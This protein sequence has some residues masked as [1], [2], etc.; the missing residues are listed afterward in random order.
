[1]A[2]S[3]E[4]V[5]QE[6]ESTRQDLSR[7]VDALS[8]KVSPTRIVGRRVEATK[9]RLGSWKEKVMGSSS[10]PS[11]STSTSGT[12]GSA[13]SDVGSALSSAPQMAR[14]Q[15]EGNPLAAGLV[16]FAGGWLVAS[17]LPA[18]RAEEQ[19]A[20]MVQD[21]ASDAAEPVKSQLADVA[22][23]MKD[24]LEPSAREAAQS[25]KDTA[26]EAATRVKEEGASVTSSGG[27]EVRQSGERASYSRQR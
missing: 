14:R 10:S 11:H 13:A 1:M 24:D 27:D 22:G 16:A 26:T 17:L 18:T 15:T 4:E 21:K 9:T 7:D 3:T 20:R 19:A 12:V 5:R 23:Q 25:V 2:Q 8:E 6:I